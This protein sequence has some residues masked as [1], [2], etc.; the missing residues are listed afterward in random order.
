[1]NLKTQIRAEEGLR[2]HAYLDTLKVPTIGVGHTGPEVHLGLVWTQAQ[3]DAQLETDLAIKTAQ[4]MARFPWVAGLNEPRQ[5]VVIGMAFQ[6]GLDGLA[7][8]RNTLANLRAGRW[9][10][11]SGGMLAS[12]WA[13]QTPER[14]NRMA[15]QVLT[16]EW[17]V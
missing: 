3:A 6:M 11:A 10:E 9:K 1:M 7:G 8:F 12:L 16:G 5:A 15:K 13:R 14:A 17:Q 2:L 4:V